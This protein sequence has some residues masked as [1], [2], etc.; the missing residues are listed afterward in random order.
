MRLTCNQGNGGQYLMEAPYTTD[1]KKWTIS[2]TR[3]CVVCH[4]YVQSTK[5]EYKSWGKKHAPWGPCGKAT[6]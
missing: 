3:L 1:G 5:E 2:T 4:Q 6:G